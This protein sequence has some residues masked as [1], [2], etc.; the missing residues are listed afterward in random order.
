MNEFMLNPTKIDRPRSVFPVHFNA[1]TT[2]EVGDIT[3]LWVEEILPGDTFSID[4]SSVV[5]GYSPFVSRVLGNLYLDIYAFFVPNR[6]VWEHWQQFC[7]ENDFGAW[8]QTNSYSLPTSSWTC[9]TDDESNVGSIGDHMSLPLSYYSDG[10]S[11]IDVNELPLRGYYRIYNEWFRNQN[12]QSPILVTYGDASLP[13]SLDYEHVLLKASRF[14]DYFSMAL[15]QPQK[16]AAVQVPL[17]ES[18]NVYIGGSGLPVNNGLASNSVQIL[19]YTS[20]GSEFNFRGVTG[21]SS[22]GDI[23]HLFAGQRVTNLSVDLSTAT[24]ATINQWRLAFQTQR[25]LETLARGGSRYIESLKSLFNVTNGDARLQRVEYLG[26]KRIPLRF[27]E[28]VN[29]TA[30][31]TGE[32]ALGQQVVKLTNGDI[33][34][35]FTKSFTEHGWLHVYGVIRYKHQYCQGLRRKFDRHDFLDFYN[36]I[37][38]NIGETPVYEKE[39][40]ARGDAE[41]SDLTVFGYQEAWADYRYIPDSVSGWLRPSLLNGLTTFT[42]GDSYT[43]APTL[44][45]FMDEPSEFVKRTVALSNDQYPFVIADFLFT[46]KMARPM[47]VSSVP[48]L[49]DHH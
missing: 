27:Q 49:I 20:N 37:F 46:G 45:G 7:G 42:F 9:V 48:G 22:G 12:T 31:S 5:F 19:G 23:G 39:I 10:S 40:Y 41:D 17:G 11:T 34:D 38:D 35:L 14:A 32:N 3:P 28:V 8:T 13:S 43:A 15:P 2:M 21:V 18:A 4:V 26:G 29:T 24:A 30:S 44:A 33:S 16:G 6:L 47:S 36:P 25:Y 1:P